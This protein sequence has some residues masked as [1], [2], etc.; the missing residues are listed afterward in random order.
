MKKFLTTVVVTGLIAGFAF[1]DSNV[2]SSANIVGYVQTETPAAGSFNIVSLV[3]FS[4]GSNTVH[5]QSAIGNMDALNASATWDNADKLI[6]W[7]GGYVTYGLYQPTVGDAYWMAD[8]IGWSFSQFASAAD[9][10][11][12]RGEGIWYKTG[13]GGVSTNATVSGDVFLDDTFDVELVGTLT[14]LSYPYSSDINLTN[15]VVSNATASAVWAEADKVIVWNGGYVQYGLYQPTVGSPYWMADGIGWSFSQFASAA[16]VKIDL[17]N[18]FWYRS[19][20]GA[21]TIGFSKIY[22][23]D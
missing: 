10:Q 7:N 11:L 5:I 9:V 18:G 3:Q 16:D 2:V 20:E 14:L 8:G 21:K 19:V 1:A 22:T 15:L 17:G 23:I 4:D 6:T 12:A 13:L